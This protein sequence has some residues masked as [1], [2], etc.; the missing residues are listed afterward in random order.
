VEEHDRET[1]SRAPTPG[2]ATAIAFAALI[3][4]SILAAIVHVTGDRPVGRALL[5]SGIHVATA[6]AAI[7]LGVV[8]VVQ[9]PVRPRTT[10]LSRR[11]LL[12]SGTVLGAGA[13]GWLALEGVLQLTGARGASRRSTGSFENGSRVPAD[14]P[15]TQWFD[16]HVQEVDA[17]SWRL[18]V[19][20]G[21]RHL[22]RRRALVVR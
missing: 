10:D 8:H 20:S 7:A 22:L 12:R 18:Q 11:S 3:V 21:S 2:R 1:R 14:M 9:R 6:V 16:D 13:A 5:S 15:V 4:T 17:S 19:L